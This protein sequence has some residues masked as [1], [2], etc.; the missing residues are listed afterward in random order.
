MGKESTPKIIIAEKEIESLISEK[1]PVF[2][3]AFEFQVKELFYIENASYIGVPKEEA[4]ASDDFEKFK[5]SMLGEFSHVYYPWNNHL[6][7]CVNSEAYFKL[8]TNRNQDLITK[9][10]QDILSKKHV[11]V[12]GLSVGSNIVTTLTQAGISQEITIAD[13]DELDTT[14]LNRILAGVHQVGLNKV[15]VAARKI[16]E[17]NPY[18]KVNSFPE[19]VTKENLHTILDSGVDLIVE[20]IDSLPFKIQTRILAMEKKLPVVMV[21]DNGDGVVLH[22]ERYDLG[23]NKIFGK[24]PSFWLELMSK[25]PP[26]KEEMAKLIVNEIVGGPDK[27]DSRMMKSVKRVIDKE[28]ISWPQLGSAAILAGVV[29]TIFVKRI[30][31]GENTDKDIRSNIFIQEKGLGSHT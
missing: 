1:Q 19:G 17:D 12:F 21:T 14:N 31:L 15:D 28:L 6:V 27:V 4:Y 3:D 5:E 20:E 16:Y 22:V 29:A 26:S 18:A 7:K 24:D 9:E 23:H 25:E 11:A 10:E 2:V 8:K 30:L 13:F